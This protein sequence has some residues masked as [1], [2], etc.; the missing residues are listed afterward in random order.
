MQ[1]VIGLKTSQLPTSV[2]LAMLLYILDLISV[3][4]YMV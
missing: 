4:D 3:F 2:N 1:G